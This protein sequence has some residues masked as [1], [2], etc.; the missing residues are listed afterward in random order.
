M[1]NERGDIDYACLFLIGSISKKVKEVKDWTIWNKSDR[2]NLKQ[3]HRKDLKHKRR[4]N[5]NI[6]EF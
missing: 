3:K 1:D 5:K 2:S 6:Y 4:E